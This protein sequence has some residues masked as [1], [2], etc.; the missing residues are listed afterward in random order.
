L[1]WNCEKEIDI[2]TET[3]EQKF[4]VSHKNFEFIANKQL[5]RPEISLHKTT[6]KH[7]K[8]TQNTQ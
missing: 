2:L 6:C 1:L 5:S 8:I 7:Q 3:Q 4:I